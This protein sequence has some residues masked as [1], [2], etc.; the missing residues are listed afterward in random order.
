LYLALDSSLLWKLYL[1]S[2]GVAVASTGKRYLVDG[3]WHCGLSYFHLGWR[4]V[5]YA[6]ANRMNLLRIL[7]IDP[8]PDPFPVYASWLQAA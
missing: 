6:L 7:W 8:S 2:S 1:A 3:H 4:W 5:K